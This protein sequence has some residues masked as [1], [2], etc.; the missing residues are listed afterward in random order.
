MVLSSQI[1]CVLSVAL[2]KLIHELPVI[3]E[4]F[5]RRIDLGYVDVFAE[6]AL[7]TF[8]NLRL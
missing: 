5:C 1:H 4:A 3:L 7:T 6:A 8:V 2:L